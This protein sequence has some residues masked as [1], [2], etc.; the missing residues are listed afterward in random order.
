MRVY[1]DREDIE[2]YGID[3]NDPNFSKVIVD[4]LQDNYFNG[5][6]KAII[7]K[8]IGNIYVEFEML[9]G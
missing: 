6:D 1:I 3:I 7:Y 2:D 8:D 5:A 4:Y 9:P